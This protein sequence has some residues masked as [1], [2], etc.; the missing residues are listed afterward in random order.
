VNR[1]QKQRITA[2]HE[3]EHYIA[4]LA[5]YRDVLRETIA[6]LCGGD[7]VIVAQYPPTLRVSMP[8]R[9]AVNSASERC[10]V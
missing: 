9:V 8:S 1:I 6:P 5:A 4:F 3:D 7:G 2:L 10:K